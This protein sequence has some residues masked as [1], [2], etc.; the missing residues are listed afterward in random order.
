MPDSAF[1]VPLTFGRRGAGAGRPSPVR[2]PRL[3]LAILLLSAILKLAVFAA[4]YAR[5]PARILT[6]DSASYEGPARALVTSGAFSRD[7]S[8]PAVTETRRT[9]GYPAFI[10]GLYR[11]F[12]PHRPAVIAAQIA[13]STLTLLIVYALAR[14]LWDT[15]T[16]TLAAL[17]LALD[18]VSFIYAQLL[19]TE[20]LF[21]FFVAALGWAGVRLLGAPND[22]PPDPP[23]PSRR[24]PLAVGVSAALAALTRPI[25]YYLMLPTLAGVLAYAWRRGWTPRRI[26]VVSLLTAMPWIALVEGWRLRNYLV[27]GSSQFSEVTGLSLLWYRGAGI[28]AERDGVSFREARRRIAR[29]LPD[30]TGWSEVEVGELYRREGLR[31]IA[32]YP[33]LF[34]KTTMYGLVKIVA[35]PGRADILHYFAGEPYEADPAGT[36]RLSAAE[37]LRRWQV[38]DPRMLACL[39]YATAYLALLYVGVGY[40]VFRLLANRAAVPL[41]PH[42]F[43][44]WLVAYL[45]VMAAGPEAYAR[46]RVP[47]MPLLALYSAHGWLRLRQG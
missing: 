29:S 16:A 25:A 43:L 26:L 45:V 46:F 9:P 30:T 28:V 44:W 32:S 40:A 34:V 31:L 3:L 4:V 14:R 15:A 42:L 8:D 36:I 27:T 21:T 24:P 5:D 7:P 41:A 1:A 37:F 47:V 20:T 17:V 19:F 2:S 12:G 39:T 6:G 13:I 11:V 18:L 35:G 22:G 33:H 10:A 38:D 23:R